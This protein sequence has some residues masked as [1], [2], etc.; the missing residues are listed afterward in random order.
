MQ[1][2]KGK[3]GRFRGNLSGKRVDFS[4]R[5]VISPDPN[6]A[7]NQVR[8]SCEDGLGTVDIS[9]DPNLTVTQVRFSCGEWE[10]A[11]RLCARPRH[12]TVLNAVGLPCICCCPAEKSPRSFSRLP[13][14]QV[15]VP[16][17]MAVVLTYPERVTPHNLDK[18]KARVLNGKVQDSNAIPT[19]QV[20]VDQVQ[21]GRVPRERAEG[22]EEGGEASGG[23]HRRE[24]GPEVCW[25]DG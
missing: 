3:Q 22:A 24:A 20:K 19:V 7:I 2:L 23:E 16:Q 11:P 8:L 1:R 17:H 18:L 10:A 21:A 6:L 12:A 14:P 25:M 15:C 4:G 13:P 5:T 9:P